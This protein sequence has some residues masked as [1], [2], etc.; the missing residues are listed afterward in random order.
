MGT[1][2]LSTGLFSE[3]PCPF[4]S[5]TRVKTDQHCWTM[6]QTAI[7][8]NNKAIEPLI[9]R[10]ANITLI[11]NDGMTLLH[12]SALNVFRTD[13]I[14]IFK[15]MIYPNKDIFLWS[16]QGDTTVSRESGVFQ[17]EVPLHVQCLKLIKITKSTHDFLINKADKKG[18]TALHLAP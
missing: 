13:G 16:S 6:L 5:T 3:G 1:T 11:D 4:K 7:C 10:G 8:R 15:T 18:R 2:G 12:Y 9:S 14:A 17:R